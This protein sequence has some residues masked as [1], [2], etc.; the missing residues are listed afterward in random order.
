M[1]ALTLYQP[2]ANLVALGKKRIETRSWR[3]RYRGPLAIHASRSFPRWAQLL[4]EQ[5]PFASALTGA[6]GRLP[7]I[8][9][10]PRGLVIAVCGLVDVYRID[11]EYLP[12]E[13]ELSF[14]IY[15]PGRWAWRLENVQRVEPPV[16]AKG[17]I[18]LWEAEQVTVF[19]VKS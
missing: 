9:D 12:L 14:G 15:A 10:F 3:T 11:P 13:P 4:V 2:Y 16:P 5:E 8:Q 18:G 7:S 17:R 19:D 6:D 1:K